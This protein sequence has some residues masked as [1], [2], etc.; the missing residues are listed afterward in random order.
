LRNH[1]EELEG[2]IERSIFNKPE[3]HHF[4]KKFHSKNGMNK[5]GG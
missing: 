1:P 4:N 3:S 2:L 5:I